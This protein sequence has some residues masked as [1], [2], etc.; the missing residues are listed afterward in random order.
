MKNRPVVIGISSLQQ[1]GKFDELDESL[2]LMEKAAMHA[3]EDTNN[4]KI[5]NYID[6]IRV[7]K[8]FWSYR[9]PGRW[10]ARNNGFNPNLKTYV[11]KIGVLQQNLINEACIK[12]QNDEIKA[13]LI[14][15]GESRYK[16]IKAILEDKEFIETKLKENPDFYIKAEEDLY[17]SE[18][19]EQLGL[20][21]VGYYAIIETALRSM[22][23]DDIDRHAERLSEMYENFSKI[24][25]LACI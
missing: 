25:F 4:Q 18:E 22:M 17:T 1:K 15:G 21:A 20:M 5:I 23:N 2:I 16:K 12:I 8:G 7:P 13:S 14:V 10:I 9:D 11:T 24:A 6:E 3:V 19:I